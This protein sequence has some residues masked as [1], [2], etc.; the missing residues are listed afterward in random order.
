VRGTEG[1]VDVDVGERGERVGEG[2]VVGGLA[3]VR[4]AGSPAAAPAGL[5]RRGLGRASSPT[6]SV[7]TRTSVAEQLGRR[8]PTGRHRGRRVRRPLRPTEVRGHDDA[9]TL[10]EQRPQGRHRRLHAQVVGDPRRGAGRSGRRGRTRASGSASRS[11]GGP[12]RAAASGHSLVP[13]ELGEVGQTGRVAHLVVVPPQPC[14]EVLRGLRRACV[15]NPV[16]SIT[17]S[18]P[19]SAPRQVGGVPLGHHAQFVAVDHQPVGARLDGPGVP[20]VHRVVLQQQGEALGIGQVVD[21]DEV[22]VEVTLLD[23]AEEV[24]TDAAEAVDGNAQTCWRAG[25]TGRRARPGMPRD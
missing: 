20:P 9:R 12:R 5:E 14:L 2:V 21:R 22:D 18:T 17:T 25:R 11:E 23:G 24:S 4:S 8:A 7:A 1:V 16:D 19:R 15:K 6:T 13:H 10:V 3:R